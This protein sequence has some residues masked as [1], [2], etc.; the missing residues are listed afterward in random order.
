MFLLCDFIYF[1]GSNVYMLFIWFGAGGKST[2]T[3]TRWDRDVFL[4]DC[5]PYLRT[6]GAMLG[7]EFQVGRV[8]WKQEELEKATI[9]AVTW[10]V[11][12]P[13]V[14]DAMGH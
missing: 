13:G 4:D 10:L 3:D 1:G 14:G 8:A 11:S 7:I 5:V 12:F 9:D 6:V 2:F